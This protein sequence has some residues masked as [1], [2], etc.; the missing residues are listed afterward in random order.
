[1]SQLTLSFITRFCSSWPFITE[2]PWW[3]IWFLIDGGHCTSAASSASGTLIAGEGEN[4]FPS[5]DSFPEPEKR[6]NAAGTN[7]SG[8]TDFSPK[9]GVTERENQ[10]ICRDSSSS[11]AV[12]KLEAEPGLRAARV[13]WWLIWAVSSISYILC[14]T[15]TGLQ[16][17]IHF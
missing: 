3:I 9:S 7:L 12:C 4:I 17:C 1:M 5:C 2:V 8:Q 15:C 10:N 16:F 6:R 11:G 13:L 14:C